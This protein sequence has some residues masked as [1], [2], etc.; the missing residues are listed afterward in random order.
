MSD[1]LTRYGLGLEQLL[2]GFT[3]SFPCVQQ[4]LN[5]AFLVRWTKGFDVEDA[6]NKDVCHLLQKEI[7]KAVSTHTQTMKPKLLLRG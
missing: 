7:Y 6:V 4:A 2:L 3:F 5:K 1:F